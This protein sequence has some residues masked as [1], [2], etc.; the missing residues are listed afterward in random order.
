MFIAER[1]AIDLF[2]GSQC[3][4]RV[5]E[6]RPVLKVDAKLVGKQAGPGDVGERFCVGQGRLGVGGVGVLPG[7]VPEVLRVFETIR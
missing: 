4:Q 3:G 2:G 5:V 6:T 7:P 1:R